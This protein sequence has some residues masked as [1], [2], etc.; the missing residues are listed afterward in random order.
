MEE[1]KAKILK[2]LEMSGAV[3]TGGDGDDLTIEDIDDLDDDLLL[4]ATTAVAMEKEIALEALG[5]VVSHTKHKFLPYFE[6]AATTVLG[7]ATHPYH[8]IRQSAIGTLWRSYS[9]LWA[10]AEDRGQGAWEPGLPLKQ[11]PSPELLKMGKAI[12]TATLEIWREEDER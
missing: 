7:L 3:E 6:S 11:M 8:G 12:M 9:S 4:G 5:D 2:A 10:I 1:T